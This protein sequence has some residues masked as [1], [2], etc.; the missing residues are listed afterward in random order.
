MSVNDQDESSEAE[1]EAQM[2]ARSGVDASEEDVSGYSERNLI[3][4]PDH[5]GLI[6]YRV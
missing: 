4:R 1:D 2:R 6:D 3:G 5:D